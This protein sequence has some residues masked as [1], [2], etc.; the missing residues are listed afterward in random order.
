MGYSLKYRY[1]PVNRVGDHICYISDLRKI[2]SHFPNWRMEYDLERI[3][4]EIV[5]RR[6]QITA[7]A[8]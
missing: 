3:I 4:S 7:A 8:S 5:E 6:L 2:Y 1:D